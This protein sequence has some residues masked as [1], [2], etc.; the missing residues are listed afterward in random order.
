VGNNYKNKPYNSHEKHPPGKSKNVF[1]DIRNFLINKPSKATFIRFKTF[2]DR[3]NIRESIMQR[4]GMDASIYEVLNV[5]K[6]GIDAPANYIF[7]EL[8]NWNGDST[9]WPNHIAKV[10]RVNGQIDNI[11]ILPFGR[12]TYPFGIKNGLFGFHFIPLFSLNAQ[13]IQSTPDSIEADNARYLLYNCSGGY[14]IGFFT[15]YVRSSIAPLNEK[16]QSQIFFVVGFDFFGRKNWTKNHLI[17]RIWLLIHN[18]VT[19]NVMNRFKELCEWRFEKIKD[20][21][22]LH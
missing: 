3:I 8:M 17:V 4:I 2:Q 7:D 12:K 16:E 1:S 20:G 11:Q 5:H 6:I 22:Y 18:R 15:M 21:E 19:Q 14:P 9:C 10:D 13:K